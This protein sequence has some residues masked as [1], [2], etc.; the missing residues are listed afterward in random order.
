MDTKSQQPPLTSV[1]RNNLQDTTL[2]LTVFIIGLRIEVVL[3]TS[4][5]LTFAITS[6]VNLKLQTASK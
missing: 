4:S 6:F 1:T 5:A 2:L 3:Q